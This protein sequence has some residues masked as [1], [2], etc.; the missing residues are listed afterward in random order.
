MEKYIE[1]LDLLVK[2]HVFLTTN[3][4]K[5]NILKAR[6]ETREKLLEFKSFLEQK[7][8]EIEN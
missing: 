5:I 3:E 1:M 8:K 2:Q 4:E 7:L 6:R